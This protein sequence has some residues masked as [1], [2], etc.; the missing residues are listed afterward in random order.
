MHYKYY[1][2]DCFDW[3][4]S[5]M[6]NS[7]TAIVTDPPYGVKEYT[8]VEMEK[9]RSGCGGIWRIPPAFDGHIRQPL[10]RFSVIN[11]NAVERETVYKYF[12][13]WGELA[14]N[15]LVPGGHV[16]IAST[17]LLSDLLSRSMRDAGFE[18]RGEIIRTVTTL[19]GGDRPKG[20]ETEFPDVSVIPRGIWEPWG[21][22]RKPLS[23]KTV[24]KNL[25]KWKA[26]ALKR[27]DD[28][29]PFCDLIESSKTPQCERKIAPHPSI[30]PQKFLRQL[31]R[32]AL[33]LSEGVILDPFAGSGSTLAAAEFFGFSS[34][35]L[36]KS[37]EFYTMGQAAIPQLAMLYSSKMENTRVQVN[38]LQEQSCF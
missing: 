19:R 12:L 18:R 8:D 3:M 14:I 37:N 2:A 9:K 10:P 26:G 36:E 33:P 28:G 4:E 27:E 30:K 7:I 21:L 35:G 17:P 1:N 11:D 29:S 38:L 15:L 20:A 34:I 16:F 6:P 22:F 5:Y 32:A 13:K 23:E 24:A 25:R 31:V